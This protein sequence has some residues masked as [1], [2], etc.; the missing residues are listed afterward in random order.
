MSYDFIFVG[1]GP[2][3]LAGA[4]CAARQGRRCLILEKKSSLNQHPRGETLRHRPI[5]DEIL[6]QGVME[7][8]ILSK[9]SCVEYYAPAPLQKE[10]ISVNTKMTH[11]I[12]EWEKFM[13]AFQKQVDSLGIELVL[14]A[15]VVDIKE[16]SGVVTGVIYKN[17][18]GKSISVTG[19]VVF[20]CDGH[21][22][23]I[24]QRL[25][26]D[27]QS[28]TYP[29]VKTLLKN[30]KFKTPGFKFFFVPTG[31]L[32]F[33]PKFPPSLAFVFPRDAISCEAGLLPMVNRG[34]KLGCEIPGKDEIFRVWKHMMQH[35]P[36]IRD[37]LSDA[38]VE[39]QELTEL[40]MTGPLNDV[41]PKKG[42]VLLGDAAGFVEISGASGLISSM[43]SATFWIN[44]IITEQNRQEDK[45]L[46]WQDQTIKQMTREYTSSKIFQ[47]IKN[48]AEKTNTTWDILFIELQTGEEI[49][50]NW[51]MIGTAMAS[52]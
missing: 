6:G 44:T 36:V 8:L 43:E 30:P 39:L 9:T 31:S 32:D 21:K 15:E 27:Y 10:K 46:L 5:V 49:M 26:V 3:G 16:S 25:G 1:A 42:V 2:A 34:E 38:S 35:H 19:D 20:A 17:P 51:E 7:S 29:I 13:D 14:R 28:I 52:Y 48:N 12:F 33:A 37:I 22:S 50:K 11:L 47:H 40:P 18:N 24:G 23:I 45:K 4:I 41:I